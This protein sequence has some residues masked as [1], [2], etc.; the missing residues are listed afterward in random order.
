MNHEHTDFAHVEKHVV[1][2]LK[3]SAPRDERARA[4]AAEIRAAGNYRW[5]GIYDV[6]ASE[7][8]IIGYSGPGAPAYPTFPRDKGLTGEMLRTGQ[9]VAVGD[10]KKDPNYLTAF[11]TTRSEMIIPVRVNDRI[12]GTIDVE[13]E[14][15]DA[16]TDA[17][18]AALERVA[19]TLAPFFSQPA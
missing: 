15:I 9:T 7:V 4:V 18:R 17:D 11:G 1:E 2:I 12:A 3:S 5:V 19:Q 13:S 16:F 14:R 10:V 6:T 8:R